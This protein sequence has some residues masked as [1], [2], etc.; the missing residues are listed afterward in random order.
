MKELNELS[1]WTDSILNEF[2]SSRVKKD[3]APVAGDRDI[4]RQAQSKYGGYD[5][6]QSLELFIADK[7]EDM[8]KRDLEQNKVIN[9][10]RRA[11]DTLRKEL[12]TMSQEVH[13]I[14]DQETSDKDEIERIRSLATGVKQEKEGNSVS[15]EEVAD[16][17]DKLNSLEKKPTGISDEEFEKYKSSLEDKIKNTDNIDPEKFEKLKSD[18][19]EFSTQSRVSKD[20]LSNVN[21]QAD[22][23][24]AKQKEVSGMKQD[25]E[26]KIASLEQEQ[27][28]LRQSE[29]SHKQEVKNNLDS[30]RDEQI[31]AIKTFAKRERGNI[32]KVVDSRTAKKVKARMNHIIDNDPKWK[33]VSKAAE[34]LKILD[35]E[36]KK[37]DEI[38]KIQNDKDSQ[39]DQA[40][41]R[42]EHYIST[43]YDTVEELED[44]LYG[45]EAADRSSQRV[46]KGH[47]PESTEQYINTLV[48]NILGPQYTKYLK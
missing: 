26:S 31:D 25:L 10:Q 32:A 29:L 9:A 7:L 20:D 8:E 4:A 28:A 21:A 48:E 19:E 22:D 5:K 13:D 1:A 45:G 30:A 41:K 40:L 43:V 24:R 47:L 6:E 42:H 44:H 18:V 16:L 17:L 39:H 15:R 46:Y 34:N 3:K 37:Q 33:E 36:I 23:L 35:Q 14:A 11:N 2:D 27:E 38:N 12:S